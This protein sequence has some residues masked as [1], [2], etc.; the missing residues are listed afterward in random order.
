MSEHW[1]DGIQEP[2]EQHYR[3]AYWL[4]PSLFFHN[5][6]ATLA[7]LSQHDANERLR[8]LWTLHS[9][10]LRASAADVEPTGLTVE[11]FSLSDSS[12]IVVISMPAPECPLEAYFGAALCSLMSDEARDRTLVV[13]YF[14]L[15]RTVESSG[16]SLT[17]MGEWTADGA[18]INH[19]SG[20]S[21][22]RESFIDAVRAISLD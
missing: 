8:G 16:T 10:E 18:H 13:R 17:V 14:T 2:R 11:L 21:P 4:L 20:P 19:G 12:L 15:E 9:N 5:T 1:P 7:A 6:E 22:S 3:V